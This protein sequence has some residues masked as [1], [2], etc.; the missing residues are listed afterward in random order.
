MLRH[1]SD[2]RHRRVR[3]WATGLRH[4]DRAVR[5][6]PTGGGSARYAGS[7]L[8]V[9]IRRRRWSEP[10]QQGHPTLT[11]RLAGRGTSSRERHPI[12]D[13]LAA[14]VLG[15]RGRGRADPHAGVHSQVRRGSRGRMR[16]SALP[17][18]S[19]APHCDLGLRA[20]GA[21]PLGG[22]RLVRRDRRDRSARGA[23][24]RV[25]GRLGSSRPPAVRF[26]FTV[27]C[28]RQW[29]VSCC[30]CRAAGAEPSPEGEAERR[31]RGELVWR[32]SAAR[33]WSGGCW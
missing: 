24:V 25:L 8:A 23:A 18:G 12:Q 28:C 9:R 1:R 33:G 4:L 19:P 10:E 14:P 31:P 22:G 7:R 27:S 29:I 21:T 26:P 11:S 6:R 13:G 15:R 3:R 16:R 2:R 32:G 5:A 30:W 17:A 20:R